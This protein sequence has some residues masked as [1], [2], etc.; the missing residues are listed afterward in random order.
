[1]YVCMYIF[2]STLIRRTLEHVCVL[3]NSTAAEQKRSVLGSNPIFPH[4]LQSCLKITKKLNSVAW[5]RERTFRPSDR[6]LSA[7]LV[8]TFADRGSHVVSATDPYGRNLGFLDR[9]RYL[10]FQVAPQ[11]YSRGSVDQV[12]DPL[13]LRQCGIVL[14]RVYFVTSFFFFSFFFNSFI[15]NQ[16]YSDSIS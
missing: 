2:H 10:F 9:S 11:L 1:M 14:I 16:N 15:R 5:A 12:P 4:P 13:L 3:R 7:M 6:L 8:P